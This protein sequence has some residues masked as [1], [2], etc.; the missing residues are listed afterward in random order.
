MLHAFFQ[1]CH[2]TRRW[3]RPVVGAGCLVLA[4]AWAVSPADADDDLDQLLGGAKPAT[5]PMPASAPIVIGGV[6]LKNDKLIQP[7]DFGRPGSVTLSN[8]VK[9]TGKVWTTPT[10][11]LRVWIEEEKAYKDIDWVLLKRIDVHLLAQ[12]MEDDWRWLQEGSDQ[13]VFSGKQYPNV[14]LA[15]KFT[16]LNDQVLEGTIV[17]PIYVQDAGKERTLALYKNYKGNLDETLKDLV[18][19]TA[20][21]LDA[22]ATPNAG[23]RPQT[24]SKLPLLGD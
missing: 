12:T 15:Y 4:A 8:G 9:L 3:L 2:P 5:N 10:V 6:V 23:T 14:N 18:Y 17:A 21:T 13:K 20:V 1:F 24:S 19:I 22:P 11:P 16:L 7:S